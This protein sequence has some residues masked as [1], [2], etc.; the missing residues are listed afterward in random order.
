MPSEARLENFMT[1]V[2]KNRSIVLL[3][4]QSNVSVNVF[5]VEIY[6][7]KQIKKSALDLFSCYQKCKL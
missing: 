2:V 1:W 6:I 4:T 7:Q 5:K 3:V